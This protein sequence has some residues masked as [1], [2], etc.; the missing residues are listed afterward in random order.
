MSY[1]I[2]YSVLSFFCNLA[3]TYS[4]FV[5]Q[6]LRFS[7]SGNKWVPVGDPNHSIQIYFCEA[8]DGINFLQVSETAGTFIVIIRTS[9]YLV[10]QIIPEDPSRVVLSAKSH[11]VHREVGMQRPYQMVFANPVLAMVFCFTYQHLLERNRGLNVAPNFEP[12]EE[13]AASDVEPD[14]ED[15]ASDADPNEGLGDA[16][17]GDDDA[18]DAGLDDAIDDD[19]SDGGYSSDEEEQPN[20]QTW[21]DFRMPGEEA[22]AL[23]EELNL[24]DDQEE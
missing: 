16:L 13:D 5:L 7:A 19:R 6:V 15:A 17:G 10:P 14:E 4:L 3:L 18:S 21:P 23:M 22:A 20:S 12:D 9:L 11:A 1:E 2:L 24:E 8:A